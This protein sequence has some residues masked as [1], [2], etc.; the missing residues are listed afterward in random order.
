MDEN[1]EQPEISV[2]D[3][4]RQTFVPNDRISRTYISAWKRFCKW[5]EDEPGNS[6]GSENGKYCTR[7]NI[8]KFFLIFVSKLTCN[9]HRSTAEVFACSLT[10]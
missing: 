6:V 1:E 2:G 10:S 8:D 9:A 5:V 4:T 7:V 3:L